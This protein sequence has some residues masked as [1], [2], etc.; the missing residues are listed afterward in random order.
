ME[1]F[2][3]AFNLMPGMGYITLQKLWNFFRDWQR[4]WE[5][6]TEKEYSSAGITDEMV[7]KIVKFRAQMDVGREYEALWEKD[8]I[9]LTRDS[10]E[11]PEPL[12]SIPSSPFLLYRKGAPLVPNDRYVS[13]VGTRIPSSYGERMTLKIAEMV[14]LCGGIVVSG[15]A[16]G[17]DAIAHFGA[18]KNEK[19][20]VAVLASGLDLVTPASHTNLAQKILE[21]GGTLLS[22]YAGETSAYKIR[23]LERNRL[24]SGLSKETIVIEA[25]QKSGALITAKHAVQQGRDVYALVGDITRPQAKGCLKLIQD[26]EAFPIVHVENLIQNLGF[27]STRDSNFSLTIEEKSIMHI[28]VSKPRSIDDLLIETK[29][30]FSTMSFLLTQLELKGVIRKNRSF[31]WE[32]VS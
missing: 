30:P 12:R 29:L 3:H 28:L 6:A 10:D 31:L 25:G 13:I 26:G 32:P 21:T 19:P 20:T 7:A 9:A 5:S 18:I 27:Q 23:F 1:P 17:I 24:I 2:L 8:I 4:A 11:Y 15:L 14:S 16:F 22:E